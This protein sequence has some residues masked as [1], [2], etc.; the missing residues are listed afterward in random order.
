MIRRSQWEHHSGAPMLSILAAVKGCPPY[1]LLKLKNDFAA[2]FAL[3]G[4]RYRRF[5]FA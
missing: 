5:D 1:D 2:A 3:R 4:M